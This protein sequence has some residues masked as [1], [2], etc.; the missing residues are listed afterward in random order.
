MQFSCPACKSM[1]TA[2]DVHS[3]STIACPACRS[4]VLVPPPIRRPLAD[5]R[6]SGVA[7]MTPAG[8]EM[9]NAVNPWAGQS[10]RRRGSLKPLLVTFLLLVLVVG[11]AGSWLYFTRIQY[12]QPIFGSGAAPEG[13][14]AATQKRGSSPR[15]TRT[16]RDELR[17]ALEQLERPQ[18][19]SQPREK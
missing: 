8:F 1:L 4:A 14:Q 18:A 7:P 15:Q 5:S 19:P 13:P 12:G 11:S 3:G 16:E 9:P 6:E 2:D 10:Y 17:E